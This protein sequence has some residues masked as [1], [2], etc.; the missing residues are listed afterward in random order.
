MARY[1]N[2]LDMANRMN[3]DGSIAAVVELLHK[4]SEM[5]PDV[6]VIE[7]NLP[8]GHRTTM[9]TGLP[10]GTWR[11]LYKGVQ[12][13]KSKTVQVTDSCGMLEAYAE[14]DKEL[15][16]LNG[17]TNEFRLDESKAFLEGMTQQISQTLVYGDTDVNPER[18]M[19]L[20]PRYNDLAA[21]NAE[22]VIDAGGTGTDNRSIWLIHFS[23]TTIHGII[24]K[25]ST[26]GLKVE[27]KGQ[28]TLKDADG[29]LYEGYRTHFQIKMGLTVRDW[30][31]AVRI[32]N[33]D[34]SLLTTDGA[35]GPKL[36]ELMFQALDRLPAMDGNVAFYMGRDVRTFWRQ[37]MPHQIKNSTL[38]Y[39]SVGGLKS[40]MFQEIPVRRVDQLDVDEARVV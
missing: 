8:I 14:V 10:Q 4:T 13:D 34:R 24:P 39:E 30:R 9:R 1:P 35:T 29:G 19:G 20:A 7:G 22:N 32:A 27:D 12:P 36:P 28:E 3:P 16:D 2:L 11:K 15:A 26:A 31:Y 6:S 33:I 23:P 25:G 5:L 18:F 37:Q 17:N 21:A 40:P 38:T